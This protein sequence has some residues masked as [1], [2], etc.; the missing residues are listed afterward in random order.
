MF[1]AGLKG[2]I[3]PNCFAVAGISCISPIAP[4]GETA[5]GLKADSTWMTART[6]S[7][8]IPRWPGVLPDQGLVGGCDRAIS[9]E[10]TGT[11]MALAA[12][13]WGRSERVRT[14]LESRHE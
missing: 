13:F 5:R 8:R 10:P 4:F 3:T 7:G 14:P 2:S 9:G 1:S 6:R 11:A 12:A